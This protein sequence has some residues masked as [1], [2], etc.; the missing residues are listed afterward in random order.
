MFNLI[1]SYYKPPNEQRQSEL[2]QCLINNAK[3][4]YI[5]RIYLLN[6]EVYNIDFVED[7]FRHKII[8][9]L[10][11]EENKSRLH[12]DIVIQFTNNYLFGQKCIVANSDIYF[13]NTL[14]FIENYNFDNTVFALTRYD[15]GELCSEPHYSQDSWIFKSPLN[16]NICQLNF[17]F[18]KP[19]CDNVFAAI[20]SKHNYNLYN[21]CFIIHTHHLHDSKY[22]SYTEKDR[23][24]GVYLYLPPM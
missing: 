16:V 12:Y 20:I 24:V 15:N 2:N 18:G 17:M 23:I 3:N 10:V 21:T 8:Q 5:N 7:E 4:Q 9:L 6:S 14:N 11:N 13:D 1:T 19:G 22:A